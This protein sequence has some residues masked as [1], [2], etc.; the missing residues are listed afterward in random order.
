MNFHIPRGLPGKDGTNGTI[1]T[2]PPGAS[3]TVDDNIVPPAGSTV[4]TDDATYVRITYAD[5]SKAEYTLSGFDSYDASGNLVSHNAKSGTWIGTGIEYYDSIVDKVTGIVNF[6]G[7]PAYKGS[8]NVFTASNTF[9]GDVV[10][11]KHV[12]FPFHNM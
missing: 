11:K 3:Q 9:E 4:T 7:N 10:F 2:A 1:A 8:D 12:S 5:G 6:V